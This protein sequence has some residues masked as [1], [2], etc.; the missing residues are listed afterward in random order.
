M[1]ELTIRDLHGW[2]LGRSSATGLPEGLLL[3]LA[4][5]GVTRY[6]ET[7]DRWHRLEIMEPG[8]AAPL[9]LCEPEAA[10][11]LTMLR[12]QKSAEARVIRRAIQELFTGLEA[13]S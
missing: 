10:K 3:R 7:V 8:K 4:I 5:I 1:P 12:G 9:W 6:L 13:P 2:L 11:L